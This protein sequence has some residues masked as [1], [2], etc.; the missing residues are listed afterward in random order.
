[1]GRTSPHY[2]DLMGEI[3]VLLE[4]S[5]DEEAGEADI[6]GGVTSR[7]VHHKGTDNF[8]IIVATPESETYINGNAAVRS[9]LLTDHKGE[10]KRGDKTLSLFQYHGGHRVNKKDTFKAIRTPLPS[11]C[12]NGQGRPCASSSGDIASTRVSRRALVEANLKRIYLGALSI[13]VPDK[14]GHR[15]AVR[16]AMLYPES[17]DIKIQRASILWL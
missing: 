5:I 12:G 8:T 6:E 17:D 16:E 10:I 13:C 9:F 2:E 11:A 7:P 3:G 14:L 4:V 1:M 15:A